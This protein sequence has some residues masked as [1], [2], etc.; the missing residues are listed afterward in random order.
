MRYAEADQ[1]YSKVY[2][3]ILDRKEFATL[4]DDHPM[5]GI[6]D[7]WDALSIEQTLPGLVM[8]HGRVWVPEMARAS[9]MEKLHLDHC[10]PD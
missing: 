8:Y 3:A 9:I 4:P 7:Y 6:K 1:D 2:Q 5:L 10:G